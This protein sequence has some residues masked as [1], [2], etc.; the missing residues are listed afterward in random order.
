MTTDFQQQLQRQ[1]GSELKD[2]VISPGEFLTQKSKEDVRL[3]TGFKIWGKEVVS[4]EVVLRVWI[5]GKEK[6]VT[7]KMRN[8][9]SEWKLSEQFFPDY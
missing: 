3:V 2:Q 7:F 9:G 1:F 4:N 8:V 5:S 6:D